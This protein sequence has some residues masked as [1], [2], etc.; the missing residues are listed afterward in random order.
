MKFFHVYNEKAFLGL[1]KNGMLNKDTGFKIQHAFS[2]PQEM[3]FNKL[4]AKG[5]RLTEFERMCDNVMVKYLKDARMHG[6]GPEYVLGFMA[7]TENDIACARIILNSFLSG[8][9]VNT[10]KERLRDTYV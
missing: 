5:G 2:L 9:S 6:F 4:A 1:E 7:A 3:Q 10:I 8:L